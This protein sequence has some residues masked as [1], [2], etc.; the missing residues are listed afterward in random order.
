VKRLIIF[1]LILSVAVSVT[2]CAQS[3]ET[4]YDFYYLR[5]PETIRH[6]EADGVIAP[7]SRDF[8]SPDAKLDYLL[9]LY[10]DGPAEDDFYSLIPN[11]TYLLKSFWEE[12]TLVLVFSREFSTLDNMQLTLAGACLSATC[13]ELTGAQRIKILSGDNTYHFDLNQF[14]FLEVS[15][16]Q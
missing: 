11:G 7:V 8:S 14:T 10:L 5:T 3:E 15:T 4:S 2:A 13:A 12:D 1:L 6:G 9:Q 16:D